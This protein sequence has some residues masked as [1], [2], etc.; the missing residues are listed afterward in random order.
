MSRNSTT[1]TVARAIATVVGLYGIV[2]FVAAGRLLDYVPEHVGVG[3]F[4]G[5]IGFAIIGAILVVI[6]LRTF[7]K[8]TP[9]FM[10]RLS[11]ITGFLLF[12]LLLLAGLRLLATLAPGLGDTWRWVL[13]LVI[14]VVACFP[15]VI[16]YDRF[17]RFLTRDA[18]PGCEEPFDRGEA[19][20]GTDARGHGE[21]E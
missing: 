21:R 14:G 4:S 17:A 3:F 15:T 2:L 5:L 20:P 1:T 8:P 18:S 19:Y 13:I 10:R 9:A 16:L 7:V 11:A 6:A 12:V